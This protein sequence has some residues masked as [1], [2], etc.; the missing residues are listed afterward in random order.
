MRASWVG[1]VCQGRLGEAAR[2]AR[3][4]GRRAPRVEEDSF[5]LV[6]DP[7]EVVCVAAGLRQRALVLV[8]RVQVWP[9]FVAQVP[10]CGD[11][12][13]DPRA[14]GVIDRILGKGYLALVE[15]D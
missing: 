3:G 8:E 10:E 14:F 13:K 7:F 4:V 6:I 5:D 2:E 9:A 15:S 1:E 11:V 12:G